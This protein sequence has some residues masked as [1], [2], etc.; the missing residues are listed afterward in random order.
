VARASQPTWCSVALFDFGIGSFV[1]TSS[2]LILVELLLAERRA[3]APV[4]S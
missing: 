2:G 1:E 3:R 4:P